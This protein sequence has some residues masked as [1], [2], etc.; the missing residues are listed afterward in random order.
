MLNFWFANMI[1]SNQLNAIE[2]DEEMFI[3]FDYI[4]ESILYYQERNV[5]KINIIAKK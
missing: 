1:Y 2:I 4:H 3:S 5:T